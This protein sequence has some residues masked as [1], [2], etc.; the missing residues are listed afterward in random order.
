MT[1]KN[2]EVVFRGDSTLRGHFLE[3]VEPYT[4]TI[5]S[6][7]AW[8]LAPFFGPGV[9]YTIDDVQYVGDRD[10]LVPAAKTT[11]AEDRTFGYR[12]SNLREWVHEKAGSRFPSKNILSVTLE[13]IRLGGVSAIEQKLLLVPKGGILIINAVQMEDMLIFILA[14]LEGNHPLFFLV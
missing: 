12:S 5:G 13:D 1:G 9:R 10:I 11:F 4:D 7:D 6:P 2:F 3:E 8:I 14:L